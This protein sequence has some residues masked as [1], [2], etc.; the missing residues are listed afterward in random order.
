LVAP[1]NTLAA[2][3]VACE[4]GIP[5]VEVDV[6]FTRDSVP[7]LIHD[8]DVRRTSN[9]SGFV[10]ALTLAELKH[11]DFGSWFG[12]Q[13]AGETIPTLAEFLALGGSCGLDLLQLDVKAFS[14]LSIDSG[15]SRIAQ[16]VREA[17]LAPL[18]MVGAADIGLLE[19][20]HR[21]FPEARRV[22]FTLSLSP[23]YAAEIVT[24]GVEAV[25]VDYAGYASS[26][27]SLLSLDSS[28]VKIGVAGLASPLAVNGLLPFPTFIITDWNW[29]FNR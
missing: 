24:E 11:L 26:A 23:S 9:G 15:W 14:P 22:L 28:G 27:A 2:V 6:R 10:D 5:G 19:S 18:V 25:S 7:V 4:L 29:R 20:A 16:D 21:V 8:R 17:R 3:R 1:E 12:R 13:F